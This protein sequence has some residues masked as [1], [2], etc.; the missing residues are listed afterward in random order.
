MEL[1][2]ITTMKKRLSTEG[3]PA[4][5]PLVPPLGFAMVAPGVYRSGHPN[6]CNF[7][8]LDGLHLTS[9][10][11]ICLDSYRPHTYNWAQDRG[12]KIFH[13]RIDSYKQPH[14]PASDPSEHAMYAEA[15]Q[16]ILDRRNLPILIHCNKGKHR[17]NTLSALLR[18]IQGWDTQAVLA[19]WDKFLGEGAPPG[20]NMIW[21]P[22]LVFL[23]QHNNHNN[24]H[25]TTNTQHQQ[26]CPTTPRGSDLPLEARD[27]PSWTTPTQNSKIKNQIVDGLARASEWEYVEQFPIHRIRVDP[28]W[29]PSWLPLESIQQLQSQ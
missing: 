28:R 14:D 10:M 11:Y 24:N 8:F 7:A 21:S 20:K 2:W 1:S 13:H 4:S 15:I 3:Q 6:H 26:H 5:P 9:I 25:I 18:I 19:E 22:G 17:V 27:S 16:Q 29:I 12:L 23:K